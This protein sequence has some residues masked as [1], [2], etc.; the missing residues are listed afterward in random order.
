MEILPLLINDQLKISI[1]SHM[2]ISKQN[3]LLDGLTNKQFFV[4]AFETIKYLGWHV[5]FISDADVIA[6]TQNSEY[7]WSGEITV[8]LVQ[9][10]EAI[11]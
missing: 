7:S 11:N 10:M 1:N 2:G 8:K 3:M 5:R 6:Y 4:I 9:D